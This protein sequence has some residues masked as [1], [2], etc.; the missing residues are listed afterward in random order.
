M[1]WKV[2]TYKLGLCLAKKMEI[3]TY[4]EMINLR[5]IIL[6]YPAI[7]GLTSFGFRLQNNLAGMILADY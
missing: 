2:N 1:L 5:Y 6:F 4:K 7:A 3:N